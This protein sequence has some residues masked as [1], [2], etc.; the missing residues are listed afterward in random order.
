MNLYTPV[1]RPSPWTISFQLYPAS[2][3]DSLGHLTDL[4][5]MSSDQPCLQP[6]SQSLWVTDKARQGYFLGNNNHQQPPTTT[7]I[8]P[9]TTFL[10]DL[11]TTNTW[12]IF[13]KDHAPRRNEGKPLKS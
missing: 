10:D 3:Q 6:P 2:V 7:M 1:T 12:W 11:S 5:S 13:M 9:R 4:E 8:Y